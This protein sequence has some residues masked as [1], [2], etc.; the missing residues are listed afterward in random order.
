MREMYVQCWHVLACASPSLRDARHLCKLASTARLNRV[1]LSLRP[2]HALETGGELR[3]VEEEAVAGLD[4]SER[5]AWRAANSGRVVAGLVEGTVLL[6]L[7][8][9]GRKGLRERVGRGSWVGVGSV[10]DLWG[11]G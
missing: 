8:A 3:A 4:R 7:L 2:G 11:R 6:G 10:V 9:V 5:G 1:N